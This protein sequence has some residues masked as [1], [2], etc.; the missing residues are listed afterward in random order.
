MRRACVTAQ[1]LVSP[2]QSGGTSHCAAYPRLVGGGVTEWVL[3]MCSLPQ[4]TSLLQT[5]EGIN[6]DLEAEAGG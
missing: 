1:T 6:V 3:G 2:G 5:D 4:S